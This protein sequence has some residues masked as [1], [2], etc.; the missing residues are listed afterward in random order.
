MAAPTHSLLG[1]PARSKK[2]ASKKQHARE[3]SGTERRALDGTGGRAAAHIVKRRRV[4]RLRIALDI[5][6][7]RHRA[8]LRLP[9]RHVPILL[10]L[11]LHL[12]VARLH[13]KAVRPLH[14]VPVVKALLN[15]VDE[16]A[17]GD[18]GGVP[19]DDRR[20]LERVVQLPVDVEFAALTLQL[21]VDLQ[22]E[23]RE[24]K[25]Q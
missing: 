13:H 7:E 5:Q 21:P 19:V 17:G 14:L 24:R 6:L 18:R 15:E 3:R 8:H 12:C 1:R 20:Q 16:I 10:R 11:A 2:Q 25:I 9:G 4:Q 23:E 22:Y